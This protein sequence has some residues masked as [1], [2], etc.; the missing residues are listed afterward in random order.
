MVDGATFFFFGRYGDRDC[1]KQ[2]NQAAGSSK[3]HLTTVR[4]LDTH[5]FENPQ[6]TLIN[7]FS[8]QF[9]N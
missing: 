1:P 6:L 8:E 4:K 7:N 9:A 5:P 3:C 2:N